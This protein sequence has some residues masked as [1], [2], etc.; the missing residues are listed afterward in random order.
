MTPSAIHEAAGHAIIALM[1]EH[2]VF[3]ISIIPIQPNHWLL[4]KHEK[5]NQHFLAKLNE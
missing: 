1:T 5:K 3:G 4:V 2:K